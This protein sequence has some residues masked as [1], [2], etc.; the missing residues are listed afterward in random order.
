MKRFRFSL[1]AL[2]TVLQQREQ[3]ALELYAKALTVRQQ[4]SEK[5]SDAQR[6]CQEAW[7]FNRQRVVSGAPA[8]QV[9]QAG[10]YCVL[11]K[12]LQERRA[13]AL[14]SA[15]QA[16]DSALEA[17]L[18]ARQSREAVDRFR[19]RQQERYNRETQREEQ[20]VID[21]LAQHVGVTS[22]GLSDKQT[23]GN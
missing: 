2:F 17:L 8:A 6:Q 21:D 11:A 12:E 15:Q 16:V 4:A 13:G 3:A 1:Q 9:V 19:A 23:G 20:K 7:D 18:E 5:L 10:Q 14:R 22:A